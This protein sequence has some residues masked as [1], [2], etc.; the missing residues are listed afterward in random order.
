MSEKAFKVSNPDKAFEY[1]REPETIRKHCQQIR[2]YVEKG[3][4]SY[5]T[6]HPE[7]WDKVTSLVCEVIQ[8]NYPSLKIPLHSRWRHID[9]GGLFRSRH[10]EEKIK[11]LPLDER[12][13]V[14]CEFIILSVLL[15]AGA[16]ASWKYEE[17]GRSYTRS[18]GLALAS[19]H[20]Y[21][22]GLFSSSENPFSVDAE[23]LFS[24]SEDTFKK[25]FQVSTENP[26]EGVQGRVELL[27]SLGRALQGNSRVFPNRRLGDIFDTL[28]L[29]CLSEDKHSR[30]KSSSEE[31]HSINPPLDAEKILKSLLHIFEDIWPT[32]LTLNDRSLGDIAHHPVVKGEHGTDGLIPFHKLSQWLT[33]SLIETFEKLGIPIENKSKLTGLAEYRNGGLFLDSGL[34]QV[35]DT[36]LSKKTHLPH[37]EVVTEWRALTICLL[38]ELAPKIRIQL[39]KPQLS[40]GQILEGGTWA[41]GRKLAFEARE[42]GNPPLEIESDGTVF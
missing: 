27:R 25:A 40:L 1:L 17:E 10:L 9:A 29:S 42:N 36:G 30:G 6:F 15:D 38:D 3:K 19:Y 4:S 7:H 33:Y 28:R 31:S 22:K 32:R 20:M 37:S 2:D 26:L 35:K 18:E 13:R 16:G 41:A 34:I 24:F 12:G 5:F 8:K 39:K 21:C 14:L 23:A 11:T